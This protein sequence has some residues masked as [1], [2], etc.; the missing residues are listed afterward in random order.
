MPQGYASPEPYAPCQLHLIFSISEAPKRLEHGL[1]GVTSGS[2]R[3]QPG[4]GSSDARI[5]HHLRI[6][7]VFPADM[8]ITFPVLGSVLNSTRRLLFGET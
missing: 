6:R 8:L 5:A 4:A 7:T 3:R 1:L 2:S